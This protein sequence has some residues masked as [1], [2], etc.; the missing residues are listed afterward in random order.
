[1]LKDLKGTELHRALDLI[2]WAAGQRDLPNSPSPA[3]VD[4]DLAL[5]ARKEGR[6]RDPDLETL[7]QLACRLVL[8]ANATGS[9]RVA[10]NQEPIVQLAARVLGATLLG[11]GETS[12]LRPNE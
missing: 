2:E 8:K 10:L 9:P 11:R 5:A 7:W 4:L 6:R 3:E 12:R 1:M